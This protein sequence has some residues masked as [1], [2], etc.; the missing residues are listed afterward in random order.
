MSFFHVW[1]VT[2]YRRATIEGEI[3]KRLKEI[4]VE[5][6][7][8]HRYRVLDFETNKDHVHILVEAT[9]RKNLSAIIRTLKAVSAKELC[10][11]PRFRVENGTSGS[12]RRQPVEESRSFWQR[13]FGFREI[14]EKEIVGMREY[15]RNQKIMY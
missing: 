7:Q 10:S 9:D 12:Y 6:I 8:R 14:D 11:T 15:I 13:R 1:F 3:E 5:C 4:F 2:K